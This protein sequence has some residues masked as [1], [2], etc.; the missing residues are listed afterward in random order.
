MLR[1]YARER[2]PFHAQRLGDLDTSRASVADLAT[3]PVMTKAEAQDRDD[4]V[5]IAC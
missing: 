1:G 5:P 4:I 3:V 2:S